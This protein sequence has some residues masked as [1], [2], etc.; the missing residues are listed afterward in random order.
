MISMQRAACTPAS[1]SQEPSGQIGAVPDTATR[2]P[3]RT[4]REK[5]IDASKGEPDVDLI[6]AMRSI[7]LAPTGPHKRGAGGEPSRA[8]A[9]SG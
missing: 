8:M 2:S 5:P 9:R 7:T 1:G 3:T 6:R 4:A